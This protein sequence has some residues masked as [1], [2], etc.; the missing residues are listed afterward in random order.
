FSENTLRYLAAEVDM[1][2]AD[3]PL[4][5]L[6]TALRGRPAVVVIRSEGCRADLAAIRSYIRDAKPALIGVD[7]GAEV[8]REYGYLPDIILGDMDSVTDATLACGA[9]L[10]VHTYA[11]GRP[12]P[13]WE[14]IQRLGAPAYALPAPGT[15]EDVAMLLAAQAGAELIVAVGTHF[16]L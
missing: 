3:L 6:R 2:T 10:V 13:G 11:D 9:E 5:P 4:P 8:L 14:R 7:G 12:S 16:S 15:S 1:A